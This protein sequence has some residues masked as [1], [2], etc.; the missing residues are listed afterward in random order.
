MGVRVL[1]RGVLGAAR[2]EKSSAKRGW[3]V[4]E[5]HCLLCQVGD[6]GMGWVGKGAVGGG[7]MLGVW[8][9]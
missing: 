9:G 7:D 8:Q 6:R 5:G 1:C 3:G 4:G 2:G